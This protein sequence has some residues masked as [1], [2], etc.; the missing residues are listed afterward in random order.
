MPTALI[1]RQPLVCGVLSLA[2]LSTPAHAGDA[3]KRSEKPM[4]DRINSKAMPAFQALADA[5]PL[6]LAWN[7]KTVEEH[8]AWRAKFHAKMIDLLGRMPQRVPFDVKWTETKN[9][10]T[11][12]LKINTIYGL[13]HPIFSKK[14]GFKIRNF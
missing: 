2:V 12:D 11:Q 4:T 10:P 5:T 9:F 7:A 1:G 6:R 3:D 8:N 13:N 14:I